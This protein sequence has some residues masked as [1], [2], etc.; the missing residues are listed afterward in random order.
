MAVAAVVALSASCGTQTVN[1]PAD[2]AVDSVDSAHSGAV[3]AAEMWVRMPAVGQTVAAAYG[4]ISNDT[5]QMVTVATVHSGLGRAELHETVSDTP[6]TDTPGTGSGGVMRM[7]HR[8]EGFELAAGAKLTFEPGGA[9]VMLFEVDVLG[10]RLAKTVTLDFEIFGWGTLSVEAEVRELDHMNHEDHEDHEQHD[11]G[12]DHG[13]DPL[14]GEA[15]DRLDVGALHRLDDELHAGIL[16]VDAG[17]Q[18][19]ADA[20]ATLKVIDIPEDFDLP[21]LIRALENLDD[22]L[23][24]GDIDLAAEWAFIV[25]DLAHALEP[26]HSH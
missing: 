8:S 1:S 3:T 4:Q 21:A 23:T 5:A 14:T 10:L 20:L 9:H 18:V 13:Q 24:N 7:Q 25:H 6:G 19:V 12:H 11:H 16:E 2:L 22:A 15:G 17:R 26:H